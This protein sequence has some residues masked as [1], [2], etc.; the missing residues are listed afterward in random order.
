[1]DMENCMSALASVCFLRSGAAAAALTLA[2]AT[3][4]AAS[5]MGLA[6]GVL[7]AVCAAACCNAQQMAQHLPY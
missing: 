2:P 6:A 7:E 4:M 3:H 5:M 1:M